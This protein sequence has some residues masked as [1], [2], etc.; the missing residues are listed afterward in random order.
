MQQLE[1]LLQPT[2]M[3]PVEKDDEE[4]GLITPYDFSSIFATPEE[5][6]KLISPYDKN[7]EL[8]KLIKG[9]T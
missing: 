3:E 5:E 7:E 8:L 9:T 2:I 6:D 4:L 1:A